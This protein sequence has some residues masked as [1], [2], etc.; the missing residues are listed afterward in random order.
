MPTLVELLDLTA[1]SDIF[2]NIELKGPLDEEFKSKYDFVKASQLII[3][4]VQ[5]YQIGNRCMVSSFSP[6]TCKTLNDLK[7]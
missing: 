6:D 7:V 4:L 3:D 5:K 2:L 1:D